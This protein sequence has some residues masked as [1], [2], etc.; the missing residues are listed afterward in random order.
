MF[1][2]IHI[3][4]RSFG[5]VFKCRDRVTNEIVAVKKIEFEDKYESVPSAVIREVSLLKELEHSNIVRFLD[6][7]SN[8]KGVDLVL[9]YLDYDLK[10]FIRYQP[11]IMEDPRVIKSFLH[12]ILSG[13]AYCHTHKILHRDLKTRNL[14][15][16]W[17]RKIVKLADFGLAR[18]FDVPLRSQT[19]K[20][21]TLPYRAPE[22]LLGSTKYS[23]P[24]DVWS[25][26]CIFA[27]MVTQKP[28]FCGRCDADVL[29]EIFRIIGVPDENTWPGVSKLGSF[30]SYVPKFP[31]DV[32]QNLADMVT[33]LEP[34]GFELLSRMLTLNPNTRIT[35]RMALSHAY[36]KDVHSAS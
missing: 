29:F 20:V 32:K 9:E 18:A 33:S 8:E 6:V 26:G 22:L 35:A 5:V 30:I 14:L 28:L 36:F 27:E 3:L 34:A 1:L 21:A 10:Q 15:V 4:E 19:V 11:R 2:L 17:E 13:V 23:T 24:V 12:Q 25:V 16:D 31:S 7:L